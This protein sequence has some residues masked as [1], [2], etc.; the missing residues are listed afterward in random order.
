MRLKISPT[1]AYVET[2]RGSLDTSVAELNRTRFEVS[3][4]QAVHNFHDVGKSLV[5]ESGKKANPLPSLTKPRAGRW[6]YFLGISEE[7]VWRCVTADYAQFSLL[8]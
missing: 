5:R 6:S 2:A 3:Q 4:K 7:L 8:G 1:S